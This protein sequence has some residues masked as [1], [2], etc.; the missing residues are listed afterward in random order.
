MEQEIEQNEIENFWINDTEIK[1]KKMKEMRNLLKYNY[2]L[3][4]DIL[5][6]ENN[7]K[8]ELKQIEDVKNLQM[9]NLNNNHRLNINKL[10]MNSKGQYKKAKFRQR[11][12]GNEITNNAWPNNT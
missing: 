5:M 6:K 8:L 12:N 4:N 1:R 3:K 11:T 9:Q 2:R 10:E 7:H